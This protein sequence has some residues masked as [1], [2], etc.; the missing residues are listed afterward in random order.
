M[1]VRLHLTWFAVVLLTGCQCGVNAKTSSDSGVNSASDGGAVGDGGNT[2]ADGGMATGCSAGQSSCGG[3]CVSLATDSNHCGNCDTVC[4][5]NATCSQGA[6]VGC[7]GGLTSCDGGCVDVRSDNAHCGTCGHA[8]PTGQGCSQ[9][10]CIPSLTMGNGPS[11]CPRAGS[12]ALQVSLPDAGSV[13]T[14]LLA[15]TTFRWGLCSCDNIKL[16]ASMVTDGFDSNLGVYRPG[17]AGGSVGTNGAF[18]SYA[19]TTLGGSLWSFGPQGL[20]STGKT[21]LR[22]ELHLA[23]PLQNSAPFSVGLDALVNGD[24]TSTAAMTVGQ[25]LHVPTGAVVSSNVTSAMVARGPVLVPPPCD[26]GDAQIIPVA[27]VVAARQANNDNATIGLNHDALLNVSKSTRLDLPCGHYYLRGISANAQVTIAA[28]GRTILYIDGDVTSRGGLNIAA[29]LGAELDVFI[30]GSVSSSAQL[31]L[32]NPGAPA[33]TRIYLASTQSLTLS[34]S[35]TLGAYLYA[36]RTPVVAS[37]LLEAFG[38]VVSGSYTA[39][40][41]TTLHYDRAVLKLAQDC[42]GG[43]VGPDGGVLGP[44]GGSS[45]PTTCS[46]CIDCGN[47]ACVG[48]VCGACTTNA[49]CCSPLLC[50]QGQCIGLN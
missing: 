33:R 13:C 10:T 41:G 37:A 45:G 7:P 42:P 21:D 14:G 27:G 9:N 34:A 1:Q 49:E 8:C 23:G 15:Q 12:T 32:G 40:A 28:H 38:G 26:C 44:D 17:E 47:Q 29:D 6:C 3:Q 4:G 30:A 39:S 22:Q 35:V 5:A 46:S 20:T 18:T 48:G 11:T 24:V 2:G 36:P 43:G 50:Y 19:T 31:R 16:S 25:T